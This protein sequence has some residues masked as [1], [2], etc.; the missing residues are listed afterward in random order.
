Y[1][2]SPAIETYSKAK[3]FAQRALQLD[4]SLAQ[5]H[6]S[7]GYTY[8]YLWLWQESEEELKRAID[9][10]PNY[11]TGHQWY[12]TFLRN[13]GRFDQSQTEIKR[14]YELDPLSVIIGQS[15]AQGYLIKGDANAAVEQCDSVLRFRR[16]LTRGWGGLNLGW[17]LRLRGRAAQVH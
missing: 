13:T 5:A 10:D 7:L 3:A 12:G 15:L 16:Y 1:A 11:A 8:N 9:L 17:V 6:T 14:A 2:G 4:S